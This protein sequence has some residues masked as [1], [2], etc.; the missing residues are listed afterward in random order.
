[1]AGALM[2]E[3]GD[4]QLAALVI[5]QVEVTDDLGF[6]RIGVR[7]M[8]GDEDARRRKDVVRRLERAAPRLR[9]LLG[10]ALGLRRVP[11][12][13]FEYDDGHDASRRVDELLHEI[14]TEPKSEDEH[15]E[16]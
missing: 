8:V 9:R 11:E 1:M 15:L 7:L 6:A 14:A 10:P 13:R 4:P 2:T 16:D 5:T 12:I 3:L